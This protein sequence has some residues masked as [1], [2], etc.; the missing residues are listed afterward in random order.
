MKSVGSSSTSIPVDG[1]DERRVEH[2]A[3]GVGG[4]ARVG[5]HLL[6]VGIVGVGSHAYG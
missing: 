4:D 1:S 2:P 6:E 3:Q 5:E